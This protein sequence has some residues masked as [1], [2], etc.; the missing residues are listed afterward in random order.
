MRCR[1]RPRLAER[2][3]EF[4]RAARADPGRAQ[5]YTCPAGYRTIGYGRLCDPKDPSITE[6]ESEVYLALNLQAALTTVT[7]RYCPVLATEP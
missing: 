4:H 6:A 5:P 2:F 3:D 1:E 7:L